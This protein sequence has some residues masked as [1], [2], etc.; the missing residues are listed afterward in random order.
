MTPIGAMN[1]GADSVMRTT[2]PRGRARGADE[3]SR[4]DSIAWKALAL[5]RWVYS[6]PAPPAT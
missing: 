4:D 5:A 6:S 2:P 1:T 3:P